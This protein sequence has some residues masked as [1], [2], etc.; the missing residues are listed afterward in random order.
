MVLIVAGHGVES[1]ILIAP[2]LDGLI[3]GINWL[4]SQGRIRW[5]FDQGRIKFGK[6]RWIKLQ[7]ETEQPYRTG[8]TQKNSP[9]TDRRIGVD[10][11][12]FH[13]APTGSAR[14]FC[15]SKLSQTL[16]C[17]VSLFCRA[18][19]QVES[20]RKRC[21]SYSRELQQCIS[22]IRQRTHDE[23]LAAL[24]QRPSCL[25][26][27][28]ASYM[29]VRGA[30]RVLGVLLRF[31]P[32]S[33]KESST[34]EDTETRKDQAEFKHF[35]ELQNN[36]GK[37]PGMSS[38]VRIVSPQRDGIL[39]GELDLYIP[40]SPVKDLATRLNIDEAR[41]TEAKDPGQSKDKAAKSARTLGE[42]QFGGAESVDKRMHP[43]SVLGVVAESTDEPMTAPLHL[44]LERNQLDLSPEST[45][46]K[47]TPTRAE[48][49]ET[50]ELSD[51]LR[52]ASPPFNG[53]LDTVE[54]HL[55]QTTESSVEERSV[56]ER[57]LQLQ[58]ILL[59][60]NCSQ[61]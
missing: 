33:N 5:D 55:R 17:E 21:E 1:E 47:M 35:K 60:D 24:S 20:G 42:V 25:L 49:M 16:L 26:D 22:D 13:A 28:W 56:K 40:A 10:G 12:D 52:E 29:I 38:A 37:T 7:Q 34:E 27:L 39:E 53:A 11:T 59:D 44:Q 48:L 46:G 9:I 23:V 15:R 54:G 43:S 32:N 57:L 50:A 30:R 31:R 58:E 2:D 6:Q 51:S 3:L 45:D 4:H 8:I 36:E 41:P 19:H 14:R 61:L 18:M